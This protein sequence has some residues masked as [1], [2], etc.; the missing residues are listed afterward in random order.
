MTYPERALEVL[1]IEAPDARELLEELEDA[2]LDRQR[3]VLL[4]RLLHQLAQRLRLSTK[5]DVR[6][7]EE[8]RWWECAGFGCGNREGGAVETYMYKP[9]RTACSVRHKSSLHVQACTDKSAL[10][11]SHC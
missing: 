9:V 8:Y 2:L 3:R 11:P 7:T 5:H 4:E 6:N 10:W 1:A